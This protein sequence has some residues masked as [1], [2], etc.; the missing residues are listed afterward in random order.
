MEL[1][2]IDL[3]TK[4]FIDWHY[5]CD[6]MYENSLCCQ[7]SFQYC[8]T[9]NFLVDIFLC[10]IVKTVNQRLC[11]FFSMVF[12]IM[13]TTFEILKEVCHKFYTTISKPASYIF[14]CILHI[15]L[16]YFFVLEGIENFYVKTLLKPPF[17]IG[18]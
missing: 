15:D 18:F 5:F 10:Y 11:A 14:I 4:G 2:H 12:I 3:W 13:K 16:I 6:G 8:F 17:L 1:L 7:K 9:M